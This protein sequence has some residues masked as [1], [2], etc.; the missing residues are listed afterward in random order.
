[1]RW[2]CR[3][4]SPNAHE[5]PLT[6]AIQ[7]LCSHGL[8]HVEWR[9]FQ[10]SSY[11]FICSLERSVVQNYVRFAFTE[12]SRLYRVPMAQS[13]SVYNCPDIRGIR[14]VSHHLLSIPTLH[15]RM[16][17]YSYV[18]SRLTRKFVRQQLDELLI[19]TGKEAVIFSANGPAGIFA[20]YPNPGIP[21][22]WTFA[23]EFFAVSTVKLRFVSSA[24]LRLS[25]L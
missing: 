15:P 19:S 8:C 22:K 20:I 5:L 13:A 2:E 17:S 14:C 24:H 10:P 7:R 16:C 4:C 23:N 6:L 9:S 11:C 12:R 25:R 21:L 18:V 3:Q 1:M